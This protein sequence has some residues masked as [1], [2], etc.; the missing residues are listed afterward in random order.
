MTHAAAT[1]PARHFAR[2][3]RRSLSATGL[4]LLASGSLWLALHYTLG[5]GAGELPHPLEAWA[6][7]LHGLAAQAGLFMLGIVAAAHIPHGWR[8]ARRPRW[9]HQRRSGLALGALCALMAATGYLLYYCAPETLRPT[10]GWGHAL[11]GAAGAAVLVWHRRGA[12]HA[13][14][15]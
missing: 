13:S 14:K 12:R 7:R 5:A 8:L 3:Q 11:T 9:A 10:L 15:G 1:P 6:L 2:W 4:L